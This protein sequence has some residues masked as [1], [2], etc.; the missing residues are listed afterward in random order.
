V[1]DMVGG[2]PDDALVR[3]REVCIREKDSLRPPP[4]RR[5]TSWCSR[6]RR[7]KPRSEFW[8]N[9]KV[10]TGLSS[11]CKD[12]QRQAT[13]ASWDKYRDRYN[14]ARRKPTE[15]RVCAA[16][17]CEVMFE[18]AMQK[19]FCSRRCKKRTENRRL[20]SGRNAA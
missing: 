4:S 18:T 19:R 5:T 9:P 6:C 14:A 7:S 1:T 20:R 12:C 2:D 17:G 10:S 16:S 8:A 15:T 3:T 11:W 13:R